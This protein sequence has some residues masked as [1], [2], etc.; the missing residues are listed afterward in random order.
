[1]I[2]AIKLTEA[3]TL[4]IA[5]AAFFVGTFFHAKYNFLK[6]YNIPEPV[7]GGI[8]ASLL[9]TGLHYSFKKDFI[10]DQEVYELL[11]LAFFATVGLTA[12]LSFFKKGGKKI[13]I[14]FF[15]AGIFLVLQNF[16]GVAFSQGLGISPFTGLLAG[17]LTL[18]GGHATGAAY[19]ELPAFAMIPNAKAMAFAFATFGLVLGG[20]IGIL[21]CI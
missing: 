5:M 21:S 16:V 9:L 18:S 3:H 12:K 13:F 20:I 11:K 6:K 7:I 1:M 8:I 17:S 15:V 19:A 2:E 4:L 14:F 10:F